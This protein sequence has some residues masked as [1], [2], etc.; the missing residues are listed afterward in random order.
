LRRVKQ[1]FFFKTS[2][3]SKEEIVNIK[4]FWGIAKC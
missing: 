1:I 3:L 4:T 2:Q